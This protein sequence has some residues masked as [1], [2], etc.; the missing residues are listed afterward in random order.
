MPCHRAAVKIPLKL[1]LFIAVLKSFDAILQALAERYSFTVI[2]GTPF[3]IKSSLSLR[4]SL[5]GDGFWDWA[6]FTAESCNQPV[7]VT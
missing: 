5:V 6:I 7:H 2:Q 3:K 1:Q 4:T